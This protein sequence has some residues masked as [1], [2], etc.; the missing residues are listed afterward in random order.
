MIE[1]IL[2][3]SGLA[4]SSGDLDAEI[5]I[6]REDRKGEGRYHTLVDG[7]VG[8]LLYSDEKTPSG[9][10][11][12]AYSTRVDSALSGRGVGLALV[13]R[14]VADARA[15]RAMIN[16]QCSFV[17]VMIGR[18]RDWADVVVEDETR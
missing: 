4:D 5:A 7:R 13:K 6:E 18:N 17:R 3:V 14:L 2:E 1:D 16:P 10:R 12:N 15:E 11:R 9:I 8:Q